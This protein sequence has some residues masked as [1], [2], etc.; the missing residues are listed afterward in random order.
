M[1][2]VLLWGVPSS[3]TPLL[4]HFGVVPLCFH[5]APTQPQGLAHRYFPATADNQ[6]PKLRPAVAVSAFAAYLPT[7]RATKVD[8]IV[9]LRY[10]AVVNA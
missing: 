5:S 1:R 7:R 10:E 4:G 2:S 3:E 6:V 9:A 8:P